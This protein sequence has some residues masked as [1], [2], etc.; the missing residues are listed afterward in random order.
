LSPEQ[1]QQVQ[2][3][4]Q[5]ALEEVNRNFSKE[6]AALFLIIAGDETQGLLKG[7]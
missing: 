5:A 2:K 1:R 4:F 7:L 3:R 6:I